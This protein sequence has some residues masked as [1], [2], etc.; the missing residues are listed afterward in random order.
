M[1]CLI[2][3]KRRFYFCATR[4][5]QLALATTITATSFKLMQ[6]ACLSQLVTFSASVYNDSTAAQCDQ[7]QGEWKSNRHLRVQVRR[8]QRKS[9]SVK[10]KRREKGRKRNS[11]FAPAFDVWFWRRGGWENG[12]GWWKGKGGKERKQML[13]RVFL[14]PSV[15]WAASW[16]WHMSINCSHCCIMTLKSHHWRCE[17]VSPYA[18]LVFFFSAS[19]SPSSS[20]LFL[21]LLL[22][23]LP[24]PFA[25][26][27]FFMA[28]E[29]FELNAWATP[30]VCF[31]T[32]WTIDH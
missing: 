19:S 26:R 5:V 9:E 2:W 3:R 12:R 28:C 31:P 1:H 29:P 30:V 8:G 32:V 17:W 18:W 11:F 7:K 4:K 27:F 6:L 15:T 10:V 24:F 14:F 25:P 21:L 20:S 22:L 13:T 23:H 16:Q